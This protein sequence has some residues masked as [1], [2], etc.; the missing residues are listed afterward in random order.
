MKFTVADLR[1]LKAM[2]ESAASDETTAVLD[3][4]R[5]RQ[6]GFCDTRDEVGRDPRCLDAWRFCGVFCYL[7]LE[8]AEAI[9]GEPLPPV[10]EY[11]YHDTACK[12]VQRDEGISKRALTYP[13]RILR[14]VLRGTDF[15]DGDTAWLQM[16]LS[17]FL[18]TV[19]TL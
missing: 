4:L 10:P 11:V 12:I 15:D 17:A 1:L 18:F 16:T 14:H 2:V 6:P 19:E 8:R 13:G 9:I 5:Q 7:A 3:S